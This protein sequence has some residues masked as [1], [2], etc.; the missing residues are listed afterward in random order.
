MEEKKNEMKW[1]ERKKWSILEIQNNPSVEL[2]FIHLLKD[3][4]EV[5]Q[6]LSLEVRLNYSP[7]SKVQR[8]DGVLTAPYGHTH[9]I[10]CLSDQDLGEGLGYGHHFTLWDTD[11]HQGASKTEE[12]QRPD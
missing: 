2:A 3:L 7:G 4:R 10:L 1:K 9:N 12:I 6:F 8:L 5:L 11:T